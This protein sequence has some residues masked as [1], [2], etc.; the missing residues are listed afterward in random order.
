MIHLSI[1]IFSASAFSKSLDLFF[2]ILFMS[3]T[4]SMV[5]SKTAKKERSNCS[6][7]VSGRSRDSISWRL[8]CLV[9]K[10]FVV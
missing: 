8:E 7:Y 5:V 4:V 2:N 6:E 1:S 10:G 9:I 3:S